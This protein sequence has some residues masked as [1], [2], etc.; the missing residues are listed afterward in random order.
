MDVA[1]EDWKR[2]WEVLLCSSGG[3]VSHSSLWGGYLS[4]WGAD[5]QG[6]ARSQC[7]LPLGSLD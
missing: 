1:K 5:V 4:P 6:A 2:P 7:G 3:L